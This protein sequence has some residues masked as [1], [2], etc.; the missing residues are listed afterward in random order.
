MTVTEQLTRESFVDS[1][2]IAK[3]Q[4]KHVVRAGFDVSCPRPV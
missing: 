2:A 4:A 3:M 1:G